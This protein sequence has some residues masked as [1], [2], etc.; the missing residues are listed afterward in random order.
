MNKPRFIKQ[1]ECI[2]QLL[3]EYANKCCAQASE[4][5]LLDKL[6][7]V[8]TE[9]LKHQTQVLTMDKCI[10]QPEDM[11]VIVFIQFGIQLFSTTISRIPVQS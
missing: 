10:L 11:V 8:D 5:V 7:K 6:I 1:A 9:Q 2:E 4:L 3:C